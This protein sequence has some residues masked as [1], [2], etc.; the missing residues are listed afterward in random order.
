VRLTEEQYADLVR[1]R[2]APVAPAPAKLR[3]YRNKPVVADGEKFDS[4][5]EASR[6]ETLQLMEKAG[7]IRDLR[8][9]VSFPLMVGDAL[10]GAY[11]ADAVYIDVATGRKVVEDSKGVRT[12][13]YRWKARHFKAQYGF[14]ITEVTKR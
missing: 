13:L 4:K 5:L 6:F 9:H 14:A 10:I 1:R 3:K 12:P 8:P 2:A 11:E 7:D